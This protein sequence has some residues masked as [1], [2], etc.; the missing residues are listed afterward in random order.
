METITPEITLEVIQRTA[1]AKEHVR[2][3]KTNIARW[4]AMY[5]MEHYSRKPKAGEIQFNDPT[6]TNT[7][8][9]TVGIMLGNR[10]QWH[11]FGF[12]PSHKEQVQTSKIEKLLD[13]ILS[14]NDERE[15]TNQLYLLYLHFTR[16]GGA[17]LYS[18][19]DPTI[20]ANS[21][22]VHTVADE[23]EGDRQVDCLREIPIRVQVIDPESIIALPGGPKRWLG[24][25]R[26]E[27]RTVLDIE[28]LY[29][30]QIPESV[31]RTQD[32]KSMI[33]GE[34]I[35]WWDYVM[36]D[37]PLRNSEGK[38]VMN[39]VLGKMETVKQLRVRNTV[40]YMG[41]PIMG[42]RIM[43]GYE[44]LPYTLQF[45]KPTGKDPDQWHS[46]I[47]PLESSISLLER[48]FNRRAKQVDVFTGLPLVTKTQPGRVVK[49]DPG[50][51]NHLQLTPDE[52]VEFP[53]WPG[54]PP[55]VNFQMDFLRARIQQS[56][57]SD[58]MFGS[59]ASQV[60]GYALSQLGD[61]NRIRLEQPITHLELLLTHWAKKSLKLLSE[62]AD[63]LDVAVFGQYRGQDYFEYVTV[64]D[65]TQFN[66]RAKIRPTYPNEETRHV[67]MASQ[68]RGVLSEYTIMERYL[69]IEQPDD[70]EERKMIEA[71]TR[72]PVAIQYSIMTELKR[73]VKEE[74]D[75]T[76]REV[77]VQLQNGQVPGAGAPVP[78]QPNP[79]QLTGTQSPT[80]QPVPQ[81]TGGVPPGQSEDEIMNNLA[82][83][84]PGMVSGM[85]E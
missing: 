34:F 32:E 47:R 24:I 42:P 7:V 67:A 26:T 80:G 83:A 41:K 62:F 81:A 31:G 44:D 60:A 27:A 33:V 37:E 55:D 63:G 72:H 9:L 20:H 50:L 25:G 22:S 36:V 66:V 51:Y 6:Y 23:Q 59:G 48:T 38:T 46:I 56:G 17:A 4:R 12:D 3:W 30:I 79:A 85:V 39:D 70:E 29:N 76:A 78:N 8:D 68:V 21:L 19:Y 10:L 75:E 1:R 43:E 69:G 65:L 71:V 58:V 84:S 18:V 5:D 15:E 52:S 35:D 45:F 82:N 40:L 53:T 77:L 13:A 11:A 73:R 16:D 54:S 14:V 74:N 49:V 64:E 57:Y 61:Q 28:S 2:D